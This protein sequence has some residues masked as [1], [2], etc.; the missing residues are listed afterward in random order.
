MAPFGMVDSPGVLCY[1]T[2]TPYRL[3]LIRLMPHVAAFAGRRITTALLP[4][5][6][7]LADENGPTAG[8]YEKGGRRY[9]I[10]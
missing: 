1:L 6:R 8:Q 4:F 9:G 5:L 7:T 2:A 10:R 3:V